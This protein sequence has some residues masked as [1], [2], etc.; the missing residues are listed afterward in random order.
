[1]LGRK[2]LYAQECLKGGFIGADFDIVQDPS[3]RLPD[4]WR[5]FNKEFIPIFLSNHPDKGRITAGLAC[6]A[7]W[8]VCK[9]IAKGDIVLCPNGTG[10]Y[11]VGEVAAGDYYYKPGETAL[12]HRLAPV[13]WSQKTASSGLRWASLCRIHRDQLAPSAR[14]LSLLMTIEKLIGGY[15]APTLTASDETVEDP[16]VFA[17][18]KHLE[19]FLVQN[20]NHTEL[21]KKYDIFQ[22]EGEFVDNSNKE[23]D[24]G[25]I[26]I[27]A[28]LQ[29]QKGTIGC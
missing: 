15:A 11:L 29:G 16:S 28:I 27:L 25:P 21:G 18:E 2:S 3:R 7:L 26:D 5:D 19:E 6:G 9:G 13:S 8:T 1:M 10:S 12:P 22:E 20:W 4:N 17:L 24:T 23:T 14:L